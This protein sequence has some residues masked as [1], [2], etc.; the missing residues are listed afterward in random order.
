MAPQ[1]TLHLPLS[2]PVR[3]TW[4]KRSNITDAL[5]MSQVSLSIII[6]II[7]IIILF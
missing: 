7:I 3:S 2:G 1:G 4:Y 6:I 5:D